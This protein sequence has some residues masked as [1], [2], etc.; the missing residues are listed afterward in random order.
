MFLGHG[1]IL[2]AKQPALHT[3]GIDIDEEIAR[4]VT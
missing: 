1:R 4:G 3:I 2:R